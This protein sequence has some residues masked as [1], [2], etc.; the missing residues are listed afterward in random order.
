MHV[1]VTGAAG[2]IGRATL[3]LLAAEAIP[4]TALSL[5]KPPTDLPAEAVVVGDAGDPDVVRRA[6]RDAD[7]VIHLAAIPSPMAD[8]GEVVFGG[9]TRATFV[10]L[11]QAG[12]AGITRASI[13]SSYSVCGLPFATRPLTLPYLPIDVNLPL[14]ITDPYALSKR[15]DELTADMVARCY[16]MNVVALRLPYIGTP[17]GR[18]PDRAALFV[19]QPQEGAAEVWSYLDARD[20]ARALLAGLTPAR[21]GAHIVYV[22]APDTLAPYPTQWLVKR[23]HPNVPSPAWPGRTVPI[24][25]APARDLLGFTARYPWPVDALAPPE[26]S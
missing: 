8:P 19:D 11:D 3:D 26:D 2:M 5:E 6:L 16:G 10:V 23:F 17:A 24:D 4:A 21:P 25:L 12:K 15:T 7:A 14:Q 18:L 1:L 22:A 9:N 13:A 20:A